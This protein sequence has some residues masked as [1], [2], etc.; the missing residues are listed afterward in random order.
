MYNWQHKEW[1]NFIFSI[2]KL[3]ELA[4]LFAQEVGLTNGL[5][6]GLNEELKQEALLEI[7]ITEAI[8]TSEIEGEYMSRE[9]VISSIKNNLGIK[10]IV[11][12]KDKRVS[13]IARLMLDVNRDLNQ[14]LTLAK[15]CNW[16]QTLME[17]DPKIN[18]VQWRKGE[19]PMQI[20]S[21][22]FGREIIHFEAPPSAQVPAEMEKFIVWY[23]HTTLPVKGH[24]S[25]ALLKAAIAH[26]YF[27]SIHPFE[28]GNGRIGRVLSEFTLS[29][30]LKSAALLSIS[31]TIEQ[32]KAKYYDQLKFAQRGLDITDWIT[33]FTQQILAAQIDAKELIRFTLKKARFYDQYTK[34]LNE[35]QLKVIQRMLENGTA[36]FDG[37]MTAKKYIAIAKTSKA[38]ATRDLQELQEI[39]AF[40]QGGAGRSVSYALVL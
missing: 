30:N 4:I 24:I 28:D 19:A 3:Q 17:Y 20:V 18:A 36:G 34:Q 8:K 29:Q 12:V 21:G 35:R 39:G 13:G 7:L 11:A 15:I 23:N 32:H 40:L 9:D 16:H 37:G 31:K 22:A 10:P 26:L 33:H 27:E 6:L 2:D 5:F 1:P 25:K 38:T 14:P